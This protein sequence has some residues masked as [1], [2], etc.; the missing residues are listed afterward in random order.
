M[1]CRT[2]SLGELDFSRFPDRRFDPLSVLA[3]EVD[4][5]AY[6]FVF[7][8]IEFHGFSPYV[9]IDLSR[10]PSDIPEISISHFA[11]PIDDTS[12]HCDTD[13][14]EMSGCLTNL[15]GGGLKVKQGAATAGTGDVVGLEYS[16]SRGLENIVTDTK[17]LPGGFLSLNENSVA[18]S[19]TNKRADVT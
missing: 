18:N 11:G 6:R 10:S 7:G 16:C 3:D 4:K 12:H 17:T 8:D 13:T 5:A 15:L 2:G 1:P 14:L 9:E 19:I